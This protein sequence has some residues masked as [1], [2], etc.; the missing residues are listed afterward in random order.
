M[1]FP[2][3]VVCMYL[4]VKDAIYWTVLFRSLS[5][6]FAGLYFASPDMHFRHNPCIGVV[7]VSGDSMTNNGAEGERGRHVCCYASV[8]C[9]G[10]CVGDDDDNGSSCRQQ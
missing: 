1:Q 3:V 10:P 6:F 9:M 5:K 2:V 8:V 4:M 7:R